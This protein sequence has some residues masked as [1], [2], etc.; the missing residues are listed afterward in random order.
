MIHVSIL[1]I[2]ALAPVADKLTSGPEIG[3]IAPALTAHVAAGIGTGE[4]RNIATVRQGQLTIYAFV[5]A[6][7]FDR[8]MARLIHT[9]DQGIADRS[10][11]NDAAGSPA[12]VTVWL[13]ETPDQSREYLPRAQQSLKLKHT[14]WTVFE[15]PLQ[16]PGGWSI[17]DSAG[18]TLV[19]V[20]RQG[21]VIHSVGF[22]SWNET[23]APPILKVL[24]VETPAP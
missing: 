9:I 12:L 14:V 22:D 13:T 1:T 15:G 18:L 7:Q 21:K 17:N 6:A 23:D 24:P 8:P 2:L 4:S 19:V 16:G 5:Q 20:D 10:S 11:E 3:A